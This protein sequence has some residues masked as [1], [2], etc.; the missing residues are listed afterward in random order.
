MKIQINVI[1]NAEIP[2]GLSPREV[3]DLCVVLD[4]AKI[5]IRKYGGEVIPAGR[6]T[7]F[8]TGDVYCDLPRE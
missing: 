4:P 6:V 8:E 2:D 5:L 7:G 3:F 1:L